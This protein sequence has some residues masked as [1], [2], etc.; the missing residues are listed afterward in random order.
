MKQLILQVTGAG[1]DDDTFAREQCR[2]QLGKGL[3][4]PCTRLRDQH[5]ILLYH[6]R[7]G[8]GHLL[9]G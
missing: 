8:G 3:T 4:G 5:P 6:L 2:N 9:L 1:R 7:N